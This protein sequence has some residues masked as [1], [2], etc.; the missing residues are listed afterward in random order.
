MDVSSPGLAPTTSSESD[1]QRW[2]DDDGNWLHPNAFPQ[3]SLTKTA[4]CQLCNTLH[5]Y[6]TVVGGRGSGCRWNCNKQKFPT[7]ASRMYL[8]GPMTMAP[9][10]SHPASAQHLP[11]FPF[12]LRS[13][14]DDVIIS[15]SPLF[16]PFPHTHISS[17]CALALCPI[18]LLVAQWRWRGKNPYIVDPDHYIFTHTGQS[19]GSPTPPAITTQSFTVG[20]R[21]VLRLRIFH[22]TFLSDIIIQNSN[23]KLSSLICTYCYIDDYESSQIT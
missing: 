23:G 21:E 14:G 12:S 7:E 18:L 22:E 8:T 4:H 19:L 17:F 13:G 3:P 5:C 10:F 11:Y 6:C 1:D 20:S 9:R 15:F 2:S 16:P